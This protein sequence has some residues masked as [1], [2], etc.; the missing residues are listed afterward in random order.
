MLAGKQAL[1]R[2][3]LRLAPF[4]RN[5]ELQADVDRVR[6]L[7]EGGVRPYSAARFLDSMGRL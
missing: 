4:S 5:Q 3:K 2:G 1:A 6:M 7:G